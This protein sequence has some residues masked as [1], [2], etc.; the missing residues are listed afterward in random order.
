MRNHG[1]G[2]KYARS[3]FILGGILYSISISNRL[4]FYISSLV[5]MT[6]V[7]GILLIWRLQMAAGFYDLLCNDWF[8]KVIGCQEI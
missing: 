3:T 8:G 1:N 4:Q 5:I 6:I 2:L 7:F